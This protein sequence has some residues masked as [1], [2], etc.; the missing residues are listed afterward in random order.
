MI[1]QEV[2]FNLGEAIH[3]RHLNPC[4]TLAR[5]G[6]GVPGGPRGHEPFRVPR[7]G[8]DW[9]APWSINRSAHSS[10]DAVQIASAQPQEDR[11]WAHSHSA[12]VP[13]Q[14]SSS[15][16]LP[17]SLNAECRNGRRSDWYRTNL[18]LTLTIY[19]ARSERGGGWGSHRSR[20]EGP[21]RKRGSQRMLPTKGHKG[22]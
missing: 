3:K 9:R 10:R 4:R 15:P 13:C 1:R 19:S 14:S 21:F 16:V 6:G 2:S 8:G 11:P 18:R 20:T 5:Q 7:A 17:K 22:T 12:S